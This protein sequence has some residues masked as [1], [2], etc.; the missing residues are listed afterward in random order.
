MAL[1][2]LVR[3]EELLTSIGWNRIDIIHFLSSD[4]DRCL[5]R[6]WDDAEQSR[7]M[8]ISWFDLRAEIEREVYVEYFE[9]VMVQEEKTEDVID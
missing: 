2:Q 3:K 8:T 6:V 9:P 4:N 1:L 7:L 5:C